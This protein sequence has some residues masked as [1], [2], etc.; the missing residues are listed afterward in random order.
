[1]RIL[2]IGQPSIETAYVARAM[3]EYSYSVKITDDMRDAEYSVSESAYDATLI[4]AAGA[5]FSA[6]VRKLLPTFTKQSGAGSILVIID[7]VAASERAAILRVGAD[8]CFARPW[9]LIEVHERLLALNRRD[10]LRAQRN[11]TGGLRLDQF[12]HELI[13][14]NSRVAV[15]RREFLAIERLLKQEGG[16]VSHDEIISYA[17]PDDD[18]A[19]S[20][21]TSQLVFRLR[22]K[23]G[24]HGIKAK[25]ETVNRFGYR[26]TE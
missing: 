16:A 13:Q 2:I 9:S 18:V 14:G 24:A 11:G 15:T 25:I 3:A 4:L 19:G 17:W 12:K 7:E 20:V 1:M 22:Q 10:V 21:N 8:A 23:M 26:L 5:S 6:S